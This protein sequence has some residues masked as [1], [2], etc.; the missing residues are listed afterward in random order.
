MSR[1]YLIINS[2]RVVYAPGHYELEIAEKIAT[3]AA[4]RHPGRTYK[5][6]EIKSTIQFPRK[7]K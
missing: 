2:G 4:R 7:K 1:D 5:V 6:V 3:N